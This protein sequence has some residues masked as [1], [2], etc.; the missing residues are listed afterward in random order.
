MRKC[1][2]VTGTGRSGT[3]MVMGLLAQ[4]GLGHSEDLIPA[5]AQNAR[6]SFEDREIFECQR[7]MLSKMGPLTIPPPKD[8]LRHPAAQQ[9]RPILRAALLKGLDAAQT[10][11]ADDPAIWG[12][13]DPHTAYTLRLWLQIFNAEKI[14]PKLVLCVRN[15]NAV[16]ASMMR[17]YDMDRSVAELVWLTRNLS[18]IRDSAADMFVAQFDKVIARD[19]AH[20]RALFS[21]SGLPP[22][23]ADAIAKQFIEKSLDHSGADQQTCQ[24][25]GVIRLWDVLR[26]CDGTTFDRNLLLQTVQ[27]I[28]ADLSHYEGWLS[29]IR[30]V[31]DKTWITNVN[32]QQSALLH[33]VEAMLNAA[34]ADP[35]MSLPDQLQDLLAQRDAD[36][37]SNIESHTKL[38]QAAE[39]IAR[40]QV[41]SQNLQK[42]L[43]KD[44]DRFRNYDR[45][46]SKQI[47]NLK[48]ELIATRRSKSFQIGHNLVM[49]V[50]HPGRNTLALPWR[51]IKLV[52]FD[53]SR[54][55]F[56]R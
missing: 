42:T 47:D 27:E 20:L 37:R 4:G 23:A 53:R 54:A 51:L 46:K 18:A 43:Q 48:K 19:D 33:E 45:N 26:T 2:V 32:A 29:E 39:E 22:A 30:R 10:A 28:E 40:L 9:A 55:Q 50:R 16:V 3:S 14:T 35:E 13:K 5:S 49:A 15:P 8:W 24:H 31:S 6:G 36:R 52:L 12:F 41:Y 11:Q 44:L 56:S 17:Q 21:F 7:D 25:P 38:V 34:G 1:L